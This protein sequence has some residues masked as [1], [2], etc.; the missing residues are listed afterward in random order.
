MEACVYRIADFVREGGWHLVATV[1]VDHMVLAAR[2]AEFYHILRN[3]DL[4]LADGMPIVWLSCLL[5]TP[6]PERVTGSDL[7][8]ELCRRSRD[9][10]LRLFFLGAEPGVAE[11]A[12]DRAEVLYPGVKIVGTS[13]PS[14]QEVEDQVAS[15]RIV[16]VVNGSGANVLLVAFGA[17]RQERWLWRHRSHLQTAVNIGVGA[18]IDFLAGRV[19]RAPRWMQD[20]GLEWLYRLTREP[21]RLGKRYLGRDLYFL[22][23]VARE[24][25]ARVK[26][27]R[28]TLRDH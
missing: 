5:R 28:A 2:D 20:A 24:L 11:A 6:L 25:A 8:I 13:S 17:P 14:R 10:G 22:S 3:A 16:E 9:L 18:S 23:I 19:K 21:R 4:V 1:N 12:K 27:N 26:S 7:T 15:R